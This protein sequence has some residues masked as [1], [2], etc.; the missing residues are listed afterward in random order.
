MGA[1]FLEV[2]KQTVPTARSTTQL[3]GMLPFVWTPSTIF[4]T[5]Q[6]SLLRRAEL[7]TRRSRSLLFQCQQA[8]EMLETAVL[9]GFYRNVSCAEKERRREGLLRPAN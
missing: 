3:F 7:R 6:Y 8:V 9:V 5:L 4:V 1:K 2:V